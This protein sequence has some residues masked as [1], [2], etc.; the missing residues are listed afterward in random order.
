MVPSLNRDQRNRVSLALWMA[1]RLA[2]T[3]AKHSKRISEQD[4]I[5]IARTALSE[6]AVPYDETK[7]TEF[8]TYAWKRVVGT[9]IRELKKEY[10]Q[11]PRVIA[12]VLGALDLVAEPDE[13]IATTLEDVSARIDERLEDFATVLFLG[14]AVEAWR[15]EGEDG[16]V[17]R[18][19]YVRALRVLHDGLATLVE[20]D[21][22]ILR[23]RWFDDLDWPTLAEEIDVSR[24]TAQRLEYDARQ[25]LKRYLLSRQVLGMPPIAR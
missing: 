9:M 25:K 5:Q 11:S 17:R 24:S 14:L 15:S 23:R 2:R 1:D 4:L 3:V 22:R 10:R 18:E 16:A 7:D 19:A 8:E 20:A 12:K 21:A 6:A 13:D